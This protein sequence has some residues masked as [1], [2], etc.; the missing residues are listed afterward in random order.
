MFDNWSRLVRENKERVKL[1]RET[2]KA[3]VKEIAHINTKTNTTK[4][5]N[6]TIKSI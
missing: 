4:D 1:R 6:N 3:D 5:K 2:N